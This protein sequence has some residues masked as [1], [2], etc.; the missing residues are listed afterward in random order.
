[1]SIYPIVMSQGEFI[2]KSELTFPF[3]E[4]G[5][6]FGDGVYEVIRIYHGEM[7]LMQE[8][9]GR[10]FRSLEA[11]RIQIEYSIEKINSMLKELIAKN[12]MQTDGYIY[13]QVSRGSASR[14]HLFPENI[15]PNMYAY[16][17]DHLVIWKD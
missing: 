1:M 6:Q 15:V 9:T 11:V 2:D 10:L 13:L 12:K 5:L 4:R 7:Y 3:E 8:H 14:V 17:V 16:L